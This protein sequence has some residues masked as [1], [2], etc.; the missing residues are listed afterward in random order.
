MGRDPGTDM[1]FHLKMVQSIRQTDQRLA[2]T[3]GPTNVPEPLREE[4]RP[5]LEGWW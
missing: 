2:R 1:F 4:L 3:N 5:A